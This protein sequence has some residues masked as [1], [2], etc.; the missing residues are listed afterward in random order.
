MIIFFAPE[1][2]LLTPDAVDSLLS[3]EFPDEETQP[4]LFGLV[5]S[6]M[7]YTPCGNENNNPNSLCIE[8]GKCGKNFPKPFQDQTIVTADSYAR[9]CRR[10]TGKKVKIGRGQSEHEVDNSW[11]VPY[12]PW[13][14]WKYRC[15]INVESI[16][17]VK[18]I[19]YIYK[20]VYKGHD[21]TTMQF[22][23]CNDEVQLYLDARYIAACEGTWCL[24]QFR[25]HEESPAVLRLQIHLPGEDLISWNEDEAPAAEVV[26]E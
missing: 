26:L 19:K 4:E 1:A 9:L 14:L 6:L 11:V 22:G 18:A 20:Y 10:D 24:Y 25:M 15:H 16:A 7:V 13:L 2:K 5:K 23:T 3:A 12:C 21:R 17:S 8:N